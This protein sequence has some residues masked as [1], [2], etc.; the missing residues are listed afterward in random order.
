MKYRI[1]IAK[2]VD[3]YQSAKKL[4]VSYSDYLGV[5][6]SFQNFDHE[7]A[8]LSEMYGG[9]E[10]SMILLEVEG[11]PVGAVGLRY[12]SDGV[13]EMKR[14]FILPE[15]QGHG[16]GDAL[17]S[18][19]IDQAKRMKY[20]CIRLDTIPRLDKAL[21]L[22]KKYGFKFIDPYRLNPDSEAV[23]MELNV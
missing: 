11:D 4:V 1:S 17:I 18:E 13:A 21:S 16:L 6:L 2:T 3:Q 15:F 23:F 7:M 14:M 22:Y 9:L 20:R 5:D 8:S 10:G 19:F 12:Y